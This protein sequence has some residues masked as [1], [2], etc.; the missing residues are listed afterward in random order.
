MDE[1]Q[2]VVTTTIDEINAQGIRKEMDSLGEV[3]VPSN[4]L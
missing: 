3:Q 2:I 1:E 4:K